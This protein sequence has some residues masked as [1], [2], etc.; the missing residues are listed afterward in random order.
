M[1]TQEIC[2][3]FEMTHNVMVFESFCD[4]SDGSLDASLMGEGPTVHESSYD[5]PSDINSESFLPTTPFF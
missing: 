2:F 5:E 4:N 1:S 3:A